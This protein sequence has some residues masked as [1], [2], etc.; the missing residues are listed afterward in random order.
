MMVSVNAATSNASSLRA[1]AS[2]PRQD[3]HP[4]APWPAAHTNTN[5]SAASTSPQSPLLASAM[6]ATSLDASPIAS[7]AL[8]G[9]D[10]LAASRSSSPLQSA[11]VSSAHSDSDSPVLP[12]AGSLVP[13][14]EEPEL[15]SPEP[16]A[17]QQPSASPQPDAPPTELRKISTES[18]P[19]D[20]PAAHADSTRSAAHAEAPGG[21]G[22]ERSGAHLRPSR[23]ADASPAAAT[24]AQKSPG[25]LSELQRGSSDAASVAS[26]TSYLTE[27]HSPGTRSPWCRSGKLQS[28]AESRELSSAST[29]ALATGFTFSQQADGDEAGALPPPCLKASAKSGLACL[30]C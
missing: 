28:A 11:R 7:Y 6:L 21:M 14:Q 2:T 27:R 5:T 29:P 20:T 18:C 13:V 26:L 17:S 19:S 25:S 23:S 9:G 22:C 8:E 15:C 10:S 12:R 3:A 16:S 4:A 30:T 24:P 1:S